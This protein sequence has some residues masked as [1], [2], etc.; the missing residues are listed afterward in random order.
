MI[1]LGIDLGGTAIKCGLVEDGTLL[2]T[3]Q[4]P[5][6]L[7]EGYRAVL[8][9]IVKAV[10]QLPEEPGASEAGLAVPGLIDPGE[11]RVLYSNNFGW[12]NRPIARDLSELL[13]MPV[14]IANDAQTAALGEA[15]YGA[16]RGCRRI[17]VI[18]IGTGVGGGFVKDGRLEED[19]S[20]GMAYIFGHMLYQAGG[21]RCNCGRAG[22]YEQY[23]S[24]GAV[25]R[26]Y[27]ELSGQAKPVREIFA[28][29]REDRHAE[30]T[31]R[32]F[33]GALGALCADIANAFRPEIIA[34][35]GGVSRSADLFLPA[36]NRILAEEV[37]GSRFAPVKA[38]PAPLGNQAGVIGAASLNTKAHKG[39][40]P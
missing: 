31:L 38:V 35:G 19:V 22:C 37:Y 1:R 3:R 7:R 15:L 30:E 39:G 13:G 40:R 29:V 14:R 5:T 28:S 34:I 33:S 20:G 32:L 27:H 4:A 8:E 18:T 11:G 26:I 24:A 2:H 9:A 16:G 6:P 12:E 21:L 17:A 36:V 23:A 10:K 25:E